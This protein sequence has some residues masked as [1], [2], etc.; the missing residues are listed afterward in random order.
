MT[1]PILWFLGRGTGVVLLALLTATTVLGVLST[2]RGFHPLW[3]R[4]VTQELHRAVSGV[5]VLVLAGHVASAVVD[6]YGDIRWWQALVPF[7]ATYEPLY[8]SLGTLALDLLA[9]VVVTSLL[10][11]RLSG[12]TWR[13]VHRA[14]YA[15]WAV[16]VVHGVGM[17]TDVA[18]PWF[19]WL[20]VTCVAL[21]A[22]ATLAR[23]VAAVLDRRQAMVAR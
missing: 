1:D 14:A 9:V 10:R 5:A 13:V 23:V 8:L 12:R 11:G 17:G 4:F 22:V 19:V 7:G 6:E 18:S 16:S 2:R 20:T 3:P 21:V 15:S